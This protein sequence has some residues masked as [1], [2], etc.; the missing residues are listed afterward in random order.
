M[1]IGLSIILIYM[2]LVALYQSWTQPLAIMLSLPVTLVGA[3]AACGL[4]AIRSTL[5]QC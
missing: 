5:S 4:R 1:A 3:L 2:L